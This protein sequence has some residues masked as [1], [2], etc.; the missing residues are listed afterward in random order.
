MKLIL[1]RILQS[2]DYFHF[3]NER[4]TV[5]F[6]TFHSSEEVEA[7][8]K[9][10]TIRIQSLGFNLYAVSHSRIPRKVPL[11]CCSLRGN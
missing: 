2:R 10:T 1:I 8:F 7:G 4:L 9:L 6:L 5:N 11:T 3:T